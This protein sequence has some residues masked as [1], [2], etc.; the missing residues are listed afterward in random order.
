MFWR[1]FSLYSAGW[2]SGADGEV[3]V[4]WYFSVL[5]LF[6]FCI[7]M[8]FLSNKSNQYFLRFP[9]TRLDPLLRSQKSWVRRSE[10]DW[11]HFIYLFFGLYLTS[12]IVEFNRSSYFLSRVRYK[13]FKFDKCI[14]E[15]AS[16]FRNFS[17]SSE[18]FPES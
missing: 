3:G 8:D 14:T 5:L 11:S 12:A 2:I 9:S 7:L 15:C 1:F 17:A 6:F 4:G 16:N 10:V 18:T 13:N